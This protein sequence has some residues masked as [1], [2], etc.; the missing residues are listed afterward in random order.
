MQ[1]ESYKSL[2]SHATCLALWQ[3]SDWRLAYGP[4][5]L[6]CF[7]WLDVVRRGS[8]WF[9]APSEDPVTSLAAAL[10]GLRMG[11]VGKCGTH[12]TLLSHVRNSRGCALLKHPSAENSGLRKSSNLRLAMTL[13]LCSLCPTAQPYCGS[14]AK[15]LAMTKDERAYRDIYPFFFFLFANL[16]KPKTCLCL[17]LYK[18]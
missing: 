17:R 6:S 16:P 12:L 1:V 7:C 4:C 8:M 15:E 14:T 13:A 9:D 10:P 18:H 5:G 11:D 3:R 2:D